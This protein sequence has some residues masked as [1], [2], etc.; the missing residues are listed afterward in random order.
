MVRTWLDQLLLG[1]LSDGQRWVWIGVLL[2]LI[3]SA[4]LLDVLGY[5]HFHLNL[6][7]LPIILAVF[8]FRERGLLMVAVM[9]G[10]YSLLQFH[11]DTGSAAMMVNNFFEL[12]VLSLVGV[13]CHGLV[14]SYRRLYRRESELAAARQEVLMTLT[15]ELRS[16]LFA[17]QG[18]IESLLRSFER[19]SPEQL[20]DQLQAAGVA[21]TL[22]NREVEGITQLF[23]VESGKLRVHP[24]RLQLEEV[25]E[26]VRSRHPEVSRR[27]HQLAFSGG[28]LELTADRLLLTQA[29]DN[30][31]TNALRHSP[32][33]LVELSGSVNDG[34]VVIAIQ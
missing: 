4:P 23:R 8:L 11:R 3:L 26:G 5:P 1:R 2:L 19:M 28:E 16:P 15:H 9:V 18:T 22:V 32:R 34:K 30:L 14:K 29:L 31:V 27:S 13:V 33:G 7:P 20:R 24:E 25:F 17:A 10:V 21:L 12:L 6:Y